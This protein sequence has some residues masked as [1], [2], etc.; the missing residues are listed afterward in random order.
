MSAVNMLWNTNGYFWDGRADKLRDQSLMP[1]EDELE[2]HETLPNV[3]AKLEQDTMYTNQFYRAFGSEEITSHRIS[4]A[5]E[6]FMNS[7]VS[8]RSKY[9]QYLAGN[10]MLTEQEER[11]IQSVLPRDIRG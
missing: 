4:L 10:A 7:I 2:M 9:D 5:L 1:I 6:Q 3:V 11:R 8:Y